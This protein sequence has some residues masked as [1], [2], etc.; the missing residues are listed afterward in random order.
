LG[1]RFIGPGR[2]VLRLRQRHRAAGAT[3]RTPHFGDNAIASA[4]PP[5]RATT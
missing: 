4:A 2:S 5:W 3:I 1:E